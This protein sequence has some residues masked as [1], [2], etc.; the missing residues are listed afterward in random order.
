MILVVGCTASLVAV[1]YADSEPQSTNYHFSESTLGAGG[2]NEEN[3]ANYK[4]GEFI[5]DLAV[6]NSASTNFQIYSGYDTTADPSLSFIVDTGS[7]NFGSFS[8]TVAS[9]TTSTFRVIDY[10]SY[11]YIVQ[12][13]GS[14]PTNGSHT[15]TPMASTNPSMVGTEQ[16]GINLVANIS[17]A[18]FGADPDNGAFGFGQAA[19]NY[20]TANNFR[21]VN[22][23]TIAT[24][25]KSSGETVYTIS[26]IVNVSSITPG[27]VYTSPQQLICI[28]TY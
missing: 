27:G 17:P 12:I 15:I 20:N 1:A 9:T 26:Y 14:P 22:G 24:G 25:P 3:S 13:Y 16:F 28:G 2:L 8:P 10:T 7:I 11:G 4:A 23:E 18:S 21:Y 19:T 5:G 6:G